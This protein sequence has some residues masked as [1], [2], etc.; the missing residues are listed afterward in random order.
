MQ[1]GVHLS[2]IYKSKKLDTTQRARE[3]GNGKQTEERLYDGIV[4]N[5]FLKNPLQR[6]FSNGEKCFCSTLSKNAGY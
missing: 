4:C 2:I 3:K 1:K 6:A 5:Q